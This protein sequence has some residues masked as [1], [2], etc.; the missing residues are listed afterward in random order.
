MAS[1]YPPLVYL[2]LFNPLVFPD[3]KVTNSTVVVLSQAG[4]NYPAPI[5]YLNVFNPYV[6]TDIH[7]A[8]LVGTSYTTNASF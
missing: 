7:P 3:T 1:Y 8:S 4:I 2:S 6:F 5:S